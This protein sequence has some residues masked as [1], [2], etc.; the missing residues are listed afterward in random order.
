MNIA[1]DAWAFK[2]ETFYRGMGRYT[3]SL[4]EA[5]VKKYPEHNFYLF[6]TVSEHTI[7]EELG[8]P[9]N[10]KEIVYFT[11]RDF[12]ME[13]HLEYCEIY[14]DLIR[15][16]ID[17]YKIDAFVLTSWFDESIPQYRKEWFSKTSLC[18]IAYDIIPYLLDEYYLPNI[19]VRNLYLDRLKFIDK[20]DVVFCISEATKNDISRLFNNDS[21]SVVIMGA[22][23]RKI[24]KKTIDN[25][26]KKSVLSKYGIHDNYIMC[27]GGDDY[28][29]NIDGLIG[30]YEKAYDKLK[31]KYQLVIVCKLRQ[32]R[33]NELL[34]NVNKNVKKDIVFTNFVPDE[35]LLVLYNLCS[36]VAFPSKYEGLG[37]PILEA[38]QCGKP[39]LTSSNSS[40]GELANGYG[41]IVDAE[42]QE[43]IEEGLIRATD[44]K[45]LEQYASLGTERV[46]EYTWEKSAGK[47]MNGIIQKCRYRYELNR[48]ISKIAYFSP[49]PPLESGIAD[50]SEDIVGKLVKK[51]NVDVYVDPGKFH[52]INKNQEN[53]IFSADEYCNAD[54]DDTIY[55]FGNSDFHEYMIPFMEKYGGI[56]E[57]HDIN[58]HGLARFLSSKERDPHSQLVNYGKIECDDRFDSTQLYSLISD[59]KRIINKYITQYA[60]KIIVHS[61]YGKENLLTKNINVPVTIIPLYCKTKLRDIKYSKK[62]MKI[63]E[64]EFVFAAF[65]IVY[66]TK[67]FRPIVEAFSSVSK[68]YNNARLYIVGDFIDDKLE[69]W[70]KEYSLTNECCKD[71]ICTGRVELEK[72]ENYMEASDVILNLRYPYNGENSASCAKAMGKGIPTIVNNIGSFSE[73]PNDACYKLPSVDTMTEDEEVKNIENAMRKL[74]TDE[75][76]RKTIADNAYKY[77]AEELDIDRVVDDM[78]DFMSYETPETQKNGLI[79]RYIEEV[80]KMD[81]TLEEKERLAEMLGFIIKV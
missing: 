74:I 58:L 65:G 80:R 54:Y 53:R 62:I 67:R 60:D 14:G 25:E 68:D 78:I 47:M 23:D 61:S 37:M 42:S 8:Y 71:I 17:S 12:Y 39:V 7:S 4:I 66:E 26:L 34:K 55:E 28:R 75:N 1:F 10:F 6:N 27:T 35:D 20:C 15:K 51:L 48:K 57:L 50:F 30:A 44:D 16:F 2:G 73:L 9:K 69:K 40:L 21:K 64:D 19:T 79:K 72:F 31:G 33:I 45:I 29:K 38:W 3:F 18:I 77:A 52:E 24:T 11:G 70:Y 49:M 63:D 56:I 36:L 13:K 81:L 22:A 5:L 32:E 46:R 43:S 59:D 76:L 41:I